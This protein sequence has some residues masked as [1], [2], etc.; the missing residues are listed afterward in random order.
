MFGVPA[1]RPVQPQPPDDGRQLVEF[2]WG[3]IHPP[4]L[5]VF[6]AAEAV[7][8]SPRLSPEVR[9]LAGLVGVG[10]VVFGLAKLG[11]SLDG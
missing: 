11:E 3:L 6:K 9:Q 10:A 2:A 5:R 8:S 4:S 7:A 1:A